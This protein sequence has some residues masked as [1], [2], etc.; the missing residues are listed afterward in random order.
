M[1][2]LFIP[3]F[4]FEISEEETRFYEQWFRNLGPKGKQL[5]I[6]HRIQFTKE[7]ERFFRFCLKK[8]SIPI[9]YGFNVCKCV[10]GHSFGSLFGLNCDMNC[11]CWKKYN[12]C[13]KCGL[14]SSL[15]PEIQQIVRLC[16]KDDDTK[17]KQ[18]ADAKNICQCVGSSTHLLTSDIFRKMFFNEHIPTLKCINCGL[19]GRDLND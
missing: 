8:I 16:K 6:S 2:S 7:D 15:S 19:N 4:S 11:H 9:S 5:F 13:E 1:A 12:C 3:G 14:S 10:K 17:A 18:I